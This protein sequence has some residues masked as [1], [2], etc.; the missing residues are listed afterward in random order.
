MQYICISM[1]AALFTQ[2]LAWC[3]ASSQLIPA[4]DSGF[5][6]ETR[7]VFQAR[8]DTMTRDLLMTHLVPEH[9]AYLI[10]AITGEIGNNSFDHNLGAWPDISGVLLGYHVAQDKKMVVMADRGQGILATLQKVKPELQHD[11]EALTTAFTEKL[12]GRAPEN[13]G[14]GLKFVRQSVE[15]QK[16]H[17]TF[18]SGNAKAE[19]S[20]HMTIEKTDAFIHGCLALLTF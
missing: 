8:L 1:E 6:C 11:E 9:Q 5:L 16:L 17:L 2:A 13:R 10:S 18:W 15:D 20:D 12:S 14:N 3:K 4:I 7:D 19:L